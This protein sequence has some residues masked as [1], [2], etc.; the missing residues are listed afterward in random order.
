MYFQEHMDK[1]DMKL[2]MN[3]LDQV[4][5]N[6]SLMKLL[7]PDC[8]GVAIMTG[9]V[10][11]LE[12]PTLAFI[13][14]AKATRIANILEVAVPVRFLIILL[15]P[16]SKDLD[17]HETGRSFGTLMSNNRFREKAY[18][19][20]DRHDLTMAISEYLEESIVLS[21]DRIVDESNFSFDMLKL[22]ADAIKERRRSKN[23]K[24]E[25]LDEK[26]Q[27]LLQEKYEE[28]K[29]KDPLRRTGRLFGGLINDLQRR[30]PYFKSDITDGL[31]TATVAT[32]LFM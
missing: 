4:I 2:S 26:T 14:L 27:I 20:N 29:R 30:M 15:G 6:D 7:P 10:S 24:A 12:Q 11:C 28:E 31:N 23:S 19:A 5:H 18:R 9:I 3:Y 17:Y 32:T 16:K 25:S 21:P 13:R 22:K 8:E 1:L